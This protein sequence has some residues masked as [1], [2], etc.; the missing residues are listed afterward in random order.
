[1]SVCV[2]FMFIFSVFV[3][4]ICDN[5]VYN[6]VFSTYFT[7]KAYKYFFTCSFDSVTFFLHSS[8]LG[9]TLLVHIANR[10]SAVYWR[11][12]QRLAVGW[13]HSHLLF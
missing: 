10:I 9:N 4:D 6:R 5:A 13:R 1:M 2:Y 8:K 3:S 11:I 12:Q 7:F